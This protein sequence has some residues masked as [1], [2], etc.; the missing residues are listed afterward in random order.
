MDLLKDQHIDDNTSSSLQELLSKHAMRISGIV[1]GRDI[2]RVA[3][4]AKDAKIA[5]LQQKIIAIET[6]REMDKTIIRHFKSDISQSIASK[7]ERGRGRG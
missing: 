2:T 4:K 3:L 1:K 7:R 5:E 6:E